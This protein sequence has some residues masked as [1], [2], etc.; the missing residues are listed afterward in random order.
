MISL[1]RGGPRMLWIQTPRPEE[2]ESFLLGRAQAR[3]Y[4]LLDAFDQAGEP[5]TL[6]FLSLP[7][8]PPTLEC[9]ALGIPEDPASLLAE[10]L[11]RRQAPLV[12][13][14]RLLPG[15]LILRTLGAVDRTIDGLREELR[16]QE[17][18][19]D[20]QIEELFH[21]SGTVLAFTEA[22]LGHRLP[23]RSLNPRVLLVPL[24]QGELLESLRSRSLRILLEGQG[25]REGWVADVRLFD[26]W[27]R[28]DLHRERL[29]RVLEALEMGL[30][31][32]ESWV[33]DFPRFMLEVRAFQMRLVSFLPP[34]E[35]KEVLLG[36]EYD[37]QG[38]RVGDF[39]LYL[40]GK[41][42][43]W[44][45][46]P[47]PRGVRPDRAALGRTQRGAL[48]GRLPAPAREALLRLDEELRRRIPGGGTDPGKTG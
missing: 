39:D 38:D 2:L 32:G 37:G 5:D 1:I 8:A 21:L 12:H 15:F 25:H 43:S 31:V 4:T 19:L 22:P 17:I 9:R 7:E 29:L 45:D 6:V 47:R 30:L 44:I 42:V 46:E 23:L 11:N 27:E 36:L 28:Y 18:P 14:V 48:E 26:Q 40:K 24:P 34:G 35:L 13:Q 20:R 3:T 41:K 33:R 16:A 10:L